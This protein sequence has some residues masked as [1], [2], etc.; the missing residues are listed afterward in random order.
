LLQAVLQKHSLFGVAAAVAAVHALGGLG[1]TP[2]SSLCCRP[3]SHVS[4]FTPSL[5][6]LT[7]LPVLLLKRGGMRLMVGLVAEELCCWWPM[8]GCELC[9]AIC[10]A[11]VLLMLLLLLLLLLLLS[12]ILLLLLL[13]RIHVLLLLLY[14]LLLQVSGSSKELCWQPRALQV[15]LLWCGETSPC[16]FHLRA[17]VLSF[18]SRMVFVIIYN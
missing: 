16:M 10:C 12:L 1:A 13:L 3:T 15:L 4:S 9:A 7:T 2:S 6:R 14:S 5:I 17:D 11:C 18:S 8:E